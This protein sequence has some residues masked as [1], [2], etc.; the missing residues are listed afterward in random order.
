ME[1][2]HDQTAV[3]GQKV[4]GA[5]QA[6]FELLQL[7]VDGNPQRL[8]SAGC[9]VNGVRCLMNDGIDDFCQFF[10]RF[11]RLN[12]AAFCNAGRNLP[13]FALLAVFVN[14]IG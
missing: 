4:N 11:N 6:V 13:R 1:R 10:G 5:F 3:R 2:N 14:Q 9:R 8:K 12:P 7:V